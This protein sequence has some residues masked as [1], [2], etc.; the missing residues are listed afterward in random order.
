[1]AGGKDG[2]TRR[3]CKPLVSPVKNIWLASDVTCIPFA[4]QPIAGKMTIN[5]QFFVFLPRRGALH[6]EGLR[7]ETVGNGRCNGRKTVFQSD[8]RLGGQS[9]LG[10]APDAVRMADE[11]ANRAARAFWAWSKTSVEERIDLL[12]R[13]AA[14]LDAERDALAEV[15]ALEV[16]AAPQWIDFNIKTAKDILLQA[17]A[18]PALMADQRVTH[19]DQ[20]VSVVRRQAVG[21]V[22]GF[23]PWNAPITLAMRAVAAPLACG[24]VV[25]LKAS[26]HCPKTHEMLVALFEKVGLPK[27]VISVVSNEAQDSFD[28]ARALIRHPTIRRINFTGST[29]VGQIVAVEAAQVM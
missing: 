16:G 22:L 13:M 1:M 6:L 3:S 29:R 4:I 14:A 23:V 27:D 9:H 24:N 19:A 11:A 2:M 18:L 20:R 21:V 28:V 10:G 26:E 12:T 7:E 5:D 17:R 15:A 8:V 25:V